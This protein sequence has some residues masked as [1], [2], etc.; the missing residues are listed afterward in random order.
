[1]GSTCVQDPPSV[2]VSIQNIAV[3]W[4]STVTVVSQQFC[5][6]CCA[7]YS[8]SKNEALCFELVCVPV[9]LSYVHVTYYIGKLGSGDISH[10]SSLHDSRRVIPAGGRCLYHIKAE[11][12]MHFW[13][14]LALHA[15][16]VS[17]VIDAWIWCQQYSG[18]CVFII[19]NEN[20][21]AKTFFSRVGHCLWTDATCQYSVWVR[22]IFKGCLLE[23]PVNWSKTCVLYR[24][25]VTV[26]RDNV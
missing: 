7:N 13:L 20:T 5:K 2:F 17:V 26:L 1:M 9:R 18:I 15:A 19:L 14:V 21:T 10:K 8:I 16:N 24:H 22:C 4:S 25:I 12:S 23:F 11:P 6:V 3:S